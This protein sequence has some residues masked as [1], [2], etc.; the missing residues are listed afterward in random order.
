LTEAPNSKLQHPDKKA[1]N[2]DI[3][4]PKKLQSI[5]LPTKSMLP[6]LLLVFG[7]SLDVGC[8]NLEL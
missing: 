2:P 3:Q 7:A 4:A 8:W 6:V 1:P 5:K